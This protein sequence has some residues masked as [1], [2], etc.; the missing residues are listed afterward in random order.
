M[1]PEQP[2]ITGQEKKESLPV[3][4][5]VLSDFYD[6]FNSRDLKK[7]SENWSQIEDIAMDNPLGGI[8]RG[9]DDIKAVYERIFS[10]PARVYVEFYNYTIHEAGEMFYAVGRERGEFRLGDIVVPLTIRTTR[11]FRMI[12]GRWRQVHHHGSID[13]SELLARYQAAVTRGVG[14]EES[15]K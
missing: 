10:G 6:A 14:P 11:I 15:M 3:P 4:L 13:E 9:W 8:K 12:D 1:K 7:M 5:R 2:P